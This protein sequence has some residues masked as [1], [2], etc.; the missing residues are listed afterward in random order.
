MAKREDLQQRLT[1]YRN[2]LEKLQ[3]A[4]L[5]LVEGQVKSY[6][7]DDRS[8]TRLDLPSLK[9]AI[10]DAE[11]KVDL[12]EDLLDGKKPRKIVAVVPRDW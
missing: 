3:D 12:L 6:E 4:Y 8:L 10:N 7:I 11:E 5:A 1:Y 2:L 9:K